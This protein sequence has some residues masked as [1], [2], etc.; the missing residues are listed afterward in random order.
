[1]LY[2]YTDY[3]NF[4][5]CDLCGSESMCRRAN[6]E[7]KSRY[8]AEDVC[9]RCDSADH[10]SQE[11]LI[12]KQLLIKIRDSGQWF[13]SALELDFEIDGEKLLKEIEALVGE[14]K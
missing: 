5:V 13:H 14:K 2:D 3:D 1:M 11:N 8:E 10:L 9:G 4:R 12:M 7:E 6:S